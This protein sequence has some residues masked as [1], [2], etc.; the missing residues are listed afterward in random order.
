MEQRQTMPRHRIHVEEFDAPGSPR[1]RSFLP[2]V[3]TFA[4]LAGIAIT[5]AAIFGPQAI[6]IA[7]QPQV[8]QPPQSPAAQKLAQAQPKATTQ[9]ALPERVPQRTETTQFESWTLICQE[10]LDKSGKKSCAAL[11]RVVEPKSKQVVFV[12]RLDFDRDGRLIAR[13]QTPTGV[14]LQSG[15]EIRLGKA[16]PRRFMFTLCDA[17]ACLAEA[18]I[19][20]PLL[21]EALSAPEGT[22]TV[23]LRDGRGLQFKWSMKGFDKALASLRAQR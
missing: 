6:S 1:K 16:D 5:L 9:A 18:V 23:M 12:W 10:K 19:E 22:A 21:K 3:L 13:M 4:L 7:Q 14:R 2:R 15:V 11:S 8:A 20:D 17:Q